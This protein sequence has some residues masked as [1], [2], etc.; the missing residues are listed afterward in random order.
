MSQRLFSDGVTDDSNIKKVS[1]T[2]AQSRISRFQCFY[3]PSLYY[4]YFYCHKCHKCHWPIKTGLSSVTV[5]VTAAFF[6]VCR[7]LRAVRCLSGVSPLRHR[8]V[9]LA[10]SRPH[11]KAFPFPVSNF[12]FL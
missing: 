12:Q 4:L 9:P 8:A 10:S 11:H 5:R 6:T 1:Q 3:M 2:P 7:H